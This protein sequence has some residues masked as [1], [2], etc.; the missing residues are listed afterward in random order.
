MM[1]AVDHRCGCLYFWKFSRGMGGWGSALASKSP[2]RSQPQKQHSWSFWLLGVSTEKVVK[3]G[4]WHGGSSVLCVQLQKGNLP[5]SQCSQKPQCSAL[6]WIF[7]RVFMA[8]LAS[9]L[10]YKTICGIGF[11]TDM[12]AAL[13]HRHGCQDFWKSRDGG[14]GV[15]VGRWGSS[16]PR[17]HSSWISQREKK[18]HFFVKMSPNFYNLQE[19]TLNK[20]NH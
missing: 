10:R 15:W 7:P 12:A 3:L 6:S 14:E 20:M 16:P 17:I 9:L 2:R 8:Y 4:H 5:S 11:W 18:C 1:V 19:D 13:N